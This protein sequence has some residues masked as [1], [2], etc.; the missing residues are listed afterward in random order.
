MSKTATEARLL[1]T[2][3]LELEE[4]NLLESFSLG[5]APAPDMNLLAHVS[6]DWSVTFETVSTG[7]DVAMRSAV[8]RMI[9]A[10]APEIVANAVAVQRG[11]VEAK[12]Q[13]LADF[14]SGRDIIRN[15]SGE[16]P[17]A[18][19]PPPPAQEDDSIDF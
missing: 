1:R 19:P 14:Q 9:A 4:L 2:L 15:G 16:T 3:S 10:N 11:I 12:R 7:A 18:A 6:V 17:P 13:E 5:S 8:A